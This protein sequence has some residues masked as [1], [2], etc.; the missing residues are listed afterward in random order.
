M[1]T[2]FS[3]GDLEHGTIEVLADYL[4][5]GGILVFNTDASFDWFYYTGS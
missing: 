1:L 5:A 2:A 3:G 4:A